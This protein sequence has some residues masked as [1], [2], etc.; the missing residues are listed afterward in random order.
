MGRSNGGIIGVSN[1]PSSVTASGVWSLQEQN[2]ARVSDNWPTSATLALDMTFI[3]NTTKSRQPATYSE[4]LAGVFGPDVDGNIS[5]GSVF[6]VSNGICTYTLP[7]NASYRIT[8]QG[9]AGGTTT[10]NL[11]TPESASGRRYGYGRIIQVDFTALAGD[12]IIFIIGQRGGSVLSN[13]GSFD[14][15]GGGGGATAVFLNSRSSPDVLV[16]AA[17]GNGSNWDAFSVQSPD[18]QPLGSSIS[19]T[20]NGRAQAGASLAS[21]G[22]NVADISSTVPTNLLGTALGGEG[23]DGG[24]ENISDPADHPGAQTPSMNGGFGGGGGALYE[25]GGGGGYEGGLPHV[26][27]DYSTLYP[28]HGALSFVGSLAS[29]SSDL[30]LNSNFVTSGVIGGN[31]LQG[32]MRIQKI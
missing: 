25:G 9:A 17:G 18:A 31:I 11:E 4:I 1:E 23:N 13:S 7:D 26:Q 20:S 19:G 27:N 28:S 12:E 6:N 24:A 15:G 2:I 21:D 22:F 10:T 29:S 16:V 8:A 30:G 5:N 3:P 32:S 14:Y